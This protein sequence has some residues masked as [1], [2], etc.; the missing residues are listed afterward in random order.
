MTYNI[1]MSYLQKVA[2]T[3]LALLVL[4]GGC[5]ATAQRAG[6]EVFYFLAGVICMPVIGTFFE[7]F[8]VI[9]QRIEND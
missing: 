3:H 2:L 8:K 6:S 1:I 5:M 4:L 7:V 9:K